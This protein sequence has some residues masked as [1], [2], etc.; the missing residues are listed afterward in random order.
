MIAIVDYGMGNLRSVAK[1]LE[2]AGAKVSLLSAPPAGLRRAAGIVLPGV[3]AFGDAMANLRSSG[4]DGWIRDAIAAGTPF[5]GICLGFQLLF[6]RSE[7]S[8]GVRGLAVIPGE[9][10]RLPATVTVPHMGWNQIRPVRP[11]DLLQGVEDGDYAYFVHSYCARPADGA[12]AA[13]VTDYG[14]EF[15]SAIG[16]GNVWGVQFHPEK[17]QAV[18]LRILSNFVGMTKTMGKG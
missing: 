8:R 1:A 14:G 5:L 12:A 10:G 4:W 7:E 6:D 16:R 11:T 17:S 18:G 2:R 15:V 9:V 3:G 13:A